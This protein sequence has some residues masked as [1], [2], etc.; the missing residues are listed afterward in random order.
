MNPLRDAPKSFERPDAYIEPRHRLWLERGELLG[1]WLRSFVSTHWHPKRLADPVSHRLTAHEPDAASRSASG[2]ALTAFVNSESTANPLPPAPAESG[3]RSDN[4]SHGYVLIGVFALILLQ[5][6]YA[7]DPSKL[8]AKVVDRDSS[9]KIDLK[10]PGSNGLLGTTLKAVIDS[11]RPALLDDYAQDMRN[12]DPA[13]PSESPVRVAAKERP[14][15]VPPYTL[16][17]YFHSSDYSNGAV[18]RQRKPYALA[19]RYENDPCAHLLPDRGRKKQ[20]AKTINP[21]SLRKI[22]HRPE[23]NRLDGLDFY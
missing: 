12:F 16:C 23:F 21:V 9:M 3:H 7:G 2:G 11:Y 20:P 17:R 19:V 5:T 14:R 10:S 22:F 1:R 8:P 15:S 4:R 13:A 18:K 6:A